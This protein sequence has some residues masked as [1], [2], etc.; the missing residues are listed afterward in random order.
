MSTKQEMSDAVIKIRNEL[1]DK[2]DWVDREDKYVI[3]EEETAFKAGFDAGY[4]IAKQETE[5]CPCG[6][7]NKNVIAACSQTGCPMIKLDAE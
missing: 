4:A 6:S 2:S 1:A 5:T 3:I 7:D